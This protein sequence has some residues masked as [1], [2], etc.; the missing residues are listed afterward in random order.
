V[1]RDLLR[2]HIQVFLAKSRQDPTRFEN[3]F[4]GRQDLAQQ[5][6]SYTKDR[7][8]AMTE[9]DVYA[10]L[11]PLWAMLIWNGGRL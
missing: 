11:S 7:I 9:E 3:D 2:K 1:N 8:R 5:Y 10:Y 4:K 6:Q